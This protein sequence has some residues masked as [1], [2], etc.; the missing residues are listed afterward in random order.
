MPT[1][2]PKADR[3]K[4]E[5][6][7]FFKSPVKVTETGIFLE[8]PVELKDRL[9]CSSGELFWTMTSGILQVSAKEPQ[10]TIPVLN[11]VED[12]NTPRA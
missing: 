10:V 4:F 5:P 9:D 12:F 11:L 6:A 2:K 3:E 8:L 1:I 7:K